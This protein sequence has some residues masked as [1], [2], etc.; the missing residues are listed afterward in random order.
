MFNA[1]NAWID[2]YPFASVPLDFVINQLETM[3]Y[4]F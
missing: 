1:A 3:A 2:T 4:M